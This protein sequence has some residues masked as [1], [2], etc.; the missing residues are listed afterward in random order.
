MQLPYTQRFFDENSDDMISST[1]S[2]RDGYRM[3]QLLQTLGFPSYTKLCVFGSVFGKHSIFMSDLLS[4]I[5][6]SKQLDEII[7]ETTDH[8]PFLYN[9]ND[10]A[11]R[12][13]FF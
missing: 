5:I 9:S 6:Y 10:A 8:T 4:Q 3:Q 11:F 7:S 13:R 2:A 1:N 12:D